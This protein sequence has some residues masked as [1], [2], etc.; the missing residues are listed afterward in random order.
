MP[1]NFEATPSL[2]R[3]LGDGLIL[4]QATAEDTEAAAEFQSQVHLPHSLAE[5]FRIWTRDL[6]SG[7]LPGSEP[8]DF[9]LVEDTSTGA[10]VSMLNLISQTWSYGGIGVGVGRIELVSTHPDY[11]RRGLVRAQMDAVH[12]MSARRGE[13][14]QVISGI[15][16]YYRQFG[17]ELALDFE[18]GYSCPVS[19][20]PALGDALREPYKVRPA[21]EGDLPFIARLYDEAM[22]RYLVSCVRDERLWK[23]ELNGKSENTFG[24]MEIRVVESASGESM[25]FL[26]HD[27]EP[28]DGD[29]PVLLYELKG[30]A[31]WLEVTPSVVRHLQRM[32]HIYSAREKGSAI[33]NVAFEL[34]AEHPV[35][36][37]INERSPRLN[38]VRAWYV[39]V[40]DITGFLR[41]VTPVLE[42]RMADSAVAG[43]TGKLTIGFVDYGVVLL[44]DSGSLTK[45]ERLAKP[46]RGDSWLSSGASDALFPG[47]IFL[48]LLMGFRTVDELEYAFP[49]CVIGSP[50]MR[51]LLNLLFPK[52]PSHIWGIS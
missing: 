38:R 13:K 49:D 19:S 51:E 33:R 7:A 16:W 25:G 41:Y 52:L 18:V 3:D 4:R 34:G 32:G 28:W 15:P 5:S 17:Y 24:E 8:G 23:Y 12:E 20:G 9:T 45:V 29:L 10:I 2:P 50:K 30:G 43:Y 42:R 39:R 35:Y 27:L 47:L 22:G 6:M 21:I 14:M 37:F 36:E 11:R 46:L 1:P 40:P 48:Q 31:S 26:V 44:F